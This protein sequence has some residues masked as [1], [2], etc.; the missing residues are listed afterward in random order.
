M[1][2]WREGKQGW[3]APSMEGLGGNVHG[4]LGTTVSEVEGSSRVINTVAH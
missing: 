2:A 4:P 1:P 3:W